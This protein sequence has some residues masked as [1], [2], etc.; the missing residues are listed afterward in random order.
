MPHHMRYNYIAY[1]DKFDVAYLDH[2]LSL[3]GLEHLAVI[4]QLIPVIEA[5][6]TLNTVE[7][8]SP[9]LGVDINETQTHLRSQA[10]HVAEYN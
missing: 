4:L 3:N 8:E 6:A 9:L 2:Y 10:L 7:A 5:T 1:K